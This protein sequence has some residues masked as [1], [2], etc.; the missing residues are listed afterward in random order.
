MTPESLTRTRSTISDMRFRSHDVPRDSGETLNGID[1]NPPE[2]AG[3]RDR[4]AHF[5]W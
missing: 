1:K 3:V 2:S 5:T 4:I